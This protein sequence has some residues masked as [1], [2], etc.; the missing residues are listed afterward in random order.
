MHTIALPMLS[1]WQYFLLFKDQK[2]PVHTHVHIQ[3]HTIKEIM[4]AQN[5]LYPVFLHQHLKNAFTLES[6]DR[7][8]IPEVEP[9]SH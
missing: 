8:L 9:Q 3:I 2:C 1:Q 4:E 5:H 6:Y 7:V